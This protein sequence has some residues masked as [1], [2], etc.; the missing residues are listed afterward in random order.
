MHPSGNDTI[1]SDKEEI[2][3][4]LIQSQHLDE[5]E[6]L[7]NQTARTASMKG[8][9]LPGRLSRIG[10]RID[11]ASKNSLPDKQSSLVLLVPG[12]SLLQ[13]P[14]IGNGDKLGNEVEQNNSGM[15]QNYCPKQQYKMN[16]N[17]LF[18]V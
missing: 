15:K 10:D 2:E 8:F 5:S 16:Q 3:Q 4:P 6:A 1:H 13:E 12:S 14:Q 7:L 18:M 17:L 9:H 11:D